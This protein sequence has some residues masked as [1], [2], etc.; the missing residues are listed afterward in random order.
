MRPT[1]ATGAAMLMERPQDNVFQ[2]KVLIIKLIPWVYGNPA[3]GPDNG[4]KN[5]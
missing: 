5:S 3:T 2:N 4:T 1:R